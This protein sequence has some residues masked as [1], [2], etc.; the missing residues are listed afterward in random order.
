MNTTTRPTAIARM[1]SWMSDQHVLEALCLW[2]MIAGIGVYLA[3]ALAGG[4]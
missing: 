3:H 1:W 4:I 2:A